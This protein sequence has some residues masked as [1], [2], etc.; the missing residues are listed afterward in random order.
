[1][2]RIIVTVVLAFVV[3]LAGC[4]MQSPYMI[5]LETPQPVATDPAMA[6]VV[7]IRPSSYGGRIKTIILDEKGRFLGESWGKTYFAVRVPPGEHTFIS[8]TE[9]T[10][11]MKATLDPGKTY[12]VE[13][14]IV[15]GA[16]TARARLFAM[17]PRRASWSKL[18]D[19]LAD[20][21]M[22]I[23]N[24]AAG[25]ALFQEKSERVREVIGKGLGSY[26]EY[27]TEAKN[28]DATAIEQ[29]TLVPADGVVR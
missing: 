15:P 3:V 28:G 23:P 11:A 21:T 29:R 27:E 24:E 26:V 6:T 22:L 8:W 25:Q 7:F 5:K 10:P 12:Y 16:W 13:V 17:G 9:G 18:T 4:A 1:M 14:G 20:C 19:W 2:N